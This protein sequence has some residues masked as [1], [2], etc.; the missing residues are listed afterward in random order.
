[1]ITYQKR[2]DLA[3][4]RVGYGLTPLALSPRWRPVIGVTVALLQAVCEALRLP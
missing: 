1:V 4:P 2:T 3:S